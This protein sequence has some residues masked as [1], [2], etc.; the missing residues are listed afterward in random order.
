M[1]RTVPIVELAI[2][3]AAVATF[4]YDGGIAIGIDSDGLRAGNTDKEF[5]VTT[6]EDP[7]SYCEFLRQLAFHIERME[8]PR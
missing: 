8:K 1:A 6:I 3:A 4:V 2:D 5:L 7:K